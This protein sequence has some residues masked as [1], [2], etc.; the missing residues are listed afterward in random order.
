MTSETHRGSC[1]C[2]ETACETLDGATGLV[3][4]GHIFCADQGDY[5]VIPQEGYRHARWTD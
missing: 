5:Y 4:E 3:T 2:G 1:L